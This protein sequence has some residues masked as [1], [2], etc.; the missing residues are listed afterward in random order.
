MVLSK[1]QYLIPCRYVRTILI[2]GHAANCCATLCHQTAVGHWT[3]ELTAPCIAVY[4]NFEGDAPF[5]DKT[6]VVD[7]TNSS[8]FYCLRCTL[9]LQLNNSCFCLTVHLKP[10]RCL[11]IYKTSSDNLWHRIFF[12][13]G[14]RELPGVRCMFVSFRCACRFHVFALQVFYFIICAITSKTWTLAKRKWKEARSLRDVELSQVAMSGM[15]E[16]WMK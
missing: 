15:G 3:G 1:S 14:V 9:S 7:S 4:D 16:K 6:S 12:L 10:R 13:F 11:V 5:E 8:G 2:H